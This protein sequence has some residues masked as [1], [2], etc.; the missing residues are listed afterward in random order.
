MTKYIILVLLLA[1]II[2]FSG[3]FVFWIISDLPK[4]KILEEYSPFESSIV[5]SADSEILAELYF[6]RRNFIPYY[7]IPAHV[8]NAFIAV[9]DK[10]FFDHHG[11]DFIRIFGAL[12][13]DI[14]AGAFIQGGSTITQQLAKMVFLKPERSIKRKIKEAA[15]SIQIERHYT[16]EEILGLYLNQTYFGSRAYGIQAA[17]RTFFGKSTVNISVSEAAL[18][19]ALLKAPSKYSPFKNPE[20]ALKRRNFVLKLM[21][22]NGFIFDTQYRAALVE[23]I[24][25]AKTKR[26]YKAPYFIEFLRQNI[27]KK[28]GDNLYTSGLKIYT[29][30][31]YRM[32]KIAEQAVKKGI[33][34]LKKSGIKDIQG[35][36]LAIDLVTGNIKALVGGTDFWES[37]FNRAIQA[38]RQ[39]GSAFKPVVYLEAL[40]QGFIAEDVIND[41]EVTY[42]GA[43]END[44]W[45][46][47]N[48]EKEYNGEVTL[49]H[50]L[51]HSLNAATVCLANIL[52]VTKIIE[53]AKRIGVKSR[54]NPYLSS[55]LGASHMTLMELVYTYGTLS[56]GK[57]LE[58]VFFSKI[59][60]REGLTLEESTYAQK[61]VID[62]GVVEE[63]R[64]M[65][66]SVVLHG[67]GKKARVLNRPVYGKTG[68]T[69][70]YTDAWFIGF[71]E[72]IA[73]GVWVG[74]DD[75][76]SIGHK[77]TG[78][79]AALPIWIE[80][81][82]NI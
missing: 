42:I 81:M 54:I 32:Q 31:D 17:S 80:F 10:R 34:D 7:S 79:R 6:E 28:Y 15:L 35:A 71:D 73:L 74:R 16:K 33:D 41:G 38:K 62:E 52:G 56:H 72:K 53:T 39:P 47:R 14:K 44:L 64:D 76:K 82:K 55:A 70:D 51:S 77:I 59:E 20:K 66:R 36:L 22:Q 4:I 23:Q 24:P 5:Y 49:N 43:D 45:T 13:R 1:L 46:P 78:S 18:L 58:P 3:G 50:A 11:I 48:Y 69:N 30:V 75:H 26:R 40:N 29:T 61:K 37:Q 19:A 8:K 21:L 57:S 68:T 67:T 9:E 63:I 60:N 2:G 12:L 65:L 25:T 27:E